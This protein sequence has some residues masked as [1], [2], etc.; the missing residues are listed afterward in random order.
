MLSSLDCFILLEEIAQIRIDLELVGIWVRLL[1]LTE[2]L[3]L[4]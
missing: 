1:A 3:D 2:L 4:C